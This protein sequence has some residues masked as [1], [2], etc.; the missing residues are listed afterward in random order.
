VVVGSG[1][2]SYRLFVSATLQGRA[3]WL[4]H[5]LGQNLGA[6][7]A[8]GYVSRFACTVAVASVS[9]FLFEKPLNDLK[10][11]FPYAASR[12]TPATVGL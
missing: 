1:F 12:K 8:N 10:R 2:G 11:Y 4:T 5:P 7:V 6:I 3:A 9:W